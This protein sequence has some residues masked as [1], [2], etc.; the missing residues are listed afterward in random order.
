MPLTEKQIEFLKAFEATM[1]ETEALVSAGALLCDLEDWDGDEEFVQEKKGVWKR[2]YDEITA[3]VVNNP[4]T[5]AEKK[6]ALE[7][8]KD[9]LG[10]RSKRAPKSSKHSRSMNGTDKKEY[11]ESRK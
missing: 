6:F 11:I 5:P 3:S 2:K 7:V 8:M 4:R 9:Q 10:L 1:N